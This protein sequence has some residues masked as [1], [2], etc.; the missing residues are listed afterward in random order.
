MILKNHC[1]CCKKFKVEK[2]NNNNG[3]NMYRKRQMAIFSTCFVNMGLT[4]I[5]SL[6]V[7]VPTNEYLKTIFAF[8][9]CFF[10]SL[11]GFFIFFVY[12]ILSKSRRAALKALTLESVRRTF[13]E[14]KAQISAIS[15]QSNQS[16]RSNDTIESTVDDKVL[17]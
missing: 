5:F 16:N 12:N 3:K 6:L 7:V 8:L 9:F 4:W 14:I 13:I 1:I 11:Q 17:R 2:S 15:L 10:N